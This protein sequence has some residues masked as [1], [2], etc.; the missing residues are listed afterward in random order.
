MCV[1]T[2]PS[3][4]GEGISGLF[5]SQQWQQPWQWDVSGEEQCSGLKSFP[6]SFTLSVTSQQG[7]GTIQSFQHIPGLALCFPTAVF[8]RGDPSPVAYIETRDLVL[9]ALGEICHHTHTKSQ[10]V[11]GTK[12]CKQQEC[13]H[14]SVPSM[15]FPF[16]ALDLNAP[17]QKSFSHFT[18]TDYGCGGV[19]VTANT[20]WEP[21]F[22]GWE[23]PA[24]LIFW[25]PSCD[26]SQTLT[27]FFFTHILLGARKWGSCLLLL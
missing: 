8:L 15:Q 26:V 12:G 21:I 23:K 11:R 22:V 6:V 24:E 1:S 14:A 3:D 10:N 20:Q 19:C 7:L 27:L 13:S 5:S 4:I 2:C 16:T 17:W 25:K 9:R 18:P